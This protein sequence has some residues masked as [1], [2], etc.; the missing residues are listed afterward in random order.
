M[1]KFIYRLF[2]TRDDDLD[3]LQVLFSSIVILSLIIIWHVTMATDTPDSVKIEA[4]I[5]LRY[6]A[7]ILVIT[8]VPS[9][10]K[11]DS[12]SPHSDVSTE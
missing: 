10:F 7:G 12:K 8:A 5:T 1:K 11:K 9:Y 4:L 6:L 3:I 2:F